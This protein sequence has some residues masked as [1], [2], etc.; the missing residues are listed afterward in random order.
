MQE[1]YSC[2]RFN[3]NRADPTQ[4]LKEMFNEPSEIKGHEG[5]SQK[6]DPNLRLDAFKN[7]FF[8]NQRREISFSLTLTRITWRPTDIK[9]ETI[10]AIRYHRSFKIK[11]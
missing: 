9:Q 1:D 10:Q 8:M 11:N 7:S 4:I 2:L 6:Y 5:T 3:K